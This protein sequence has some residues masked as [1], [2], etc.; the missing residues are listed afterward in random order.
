M[1]GLSAAAKGALALGVDTQVVLDGRP[2]GKAEPP[3]DVQD[4]HDRALQ[5][6]GAVNDFRRLRQGG[7]VDHPHGPLHCRK[8]HGITRVFDGEDYQLIGVNHGMPHG[9]YSG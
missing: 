8:G 9:E 3:A 4:R 5:V 6:D 1:C 2:L 7:D